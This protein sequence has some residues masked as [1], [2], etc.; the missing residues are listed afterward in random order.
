MS[1]SANLPQIHHNVLWIDTPDNFRRMLDALLRQPLVAVDTESDS[2]Y[3]YYEKVCLIQF[4]VPGVDYL[5]DPLAIDVSDL[6]GLFTSPAIQKIFHAAEYDFL[7]LKRDYAFQFSNLFDTMVAARILG[8]P[9][10]GLASLLDEHFGV[11]LNKR[12]QRYNWGRRPL[13]QKALDYAHLDT[14]YL[15]PL[16]QTQLDALKRHNRLREANEAWE[17]LTRVEPTPK[18]FDPDDFWRIK[19]AR[20]L[21]PRQ[22]AVL[23]EL[24]I[25]RDQIARHL[26][27]PPFKVMTDKVLVELA[28]TQPHS[29]NNLSQIKGVGGKLLHHNGDK[30][31][32]AIR[33]GQAA[34]PPRQ[35][36][37]KNHQRPDSL[38]MLRY[39]SLRQ[40][41]N[42]LAAQRGVEPDVIINNHTLMDIAR[43]NP[44]TLQNLN[45]L[46]VLGDW[47]RETYGHT[48]LTVLKAAAI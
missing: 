38:T 17:R 26:N 13:S 35:R 42:D 28:K 10:Y 19:S 1:K 8:W 44:Q 45:Q 40:W 27:R 2:L 11:Q 18:V 29:P 9:R 39:E 41:R 20:E 32:E 14:H 3:S 46:G 33:A 37:N 24:F 16:R 15:I 6:A 36:L 43:Y 21:S 30:I 23:R 34:T 5:V 48:L 31:L 12:F 4:S 25:L 7:S 47:Q 22:Q